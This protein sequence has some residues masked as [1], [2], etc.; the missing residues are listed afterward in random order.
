MQ[1][2]VSKK[3]TVLVT[4]WVVLIFIGVGSVS[5]ISNR[6]NQQYEDS[7]Y[8]HKVMN[9][10]VRSFHP[11]AYQDSIARVKQ[12]RKIEKLLKDIRK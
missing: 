11:S 7:I 5:Y 12:E 10:P 6:V 3:I 4:I 8:Y 2:K 1:R 9:A